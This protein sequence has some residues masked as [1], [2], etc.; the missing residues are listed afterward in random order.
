MEAS[1]MKGQAG[2]LISVIL[3]QLIVCW[4]QP[5]AA[6][7]ETTEEW[8]ALGVKHRKRLEPERALEAF[9]RAHELAPTARSR[10][11]MGFVEHDLGRYLEA[12]QHLSEALAAERDPWVIRNRK[13][14]G[15]ALALTRSHLG[16]VTVDGP[17]GA[18]VRLGGAPVG[19]LPLNGPISST[20]GK[21]SVT[22][23]AAGY[24]PWEQQLTI[25]GG[26][27][28]RLTAD[29]VPDRRDLPLLPPRD[30]ALRSDDTVDM[31]GTRNDGRDDEER[32][33]GGRWTRATAW[34]LMGVGAALAGAAVWAHTSRQPGCPRG[35]RVCNRG[36]R[37]SWPT[38][39]LAAGSLV[40]GVGSM[41]LFIW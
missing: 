34:T 22:V 29:L 32:P 26:R 35:E 18:A 16:R 11:Q 41:T 4:P 8:N 15:E 28:V 31:M 2:R 39:G 17:P 36:T 33:R 9:R 21:T 10:G 13:F 25:T 1:V 24:L 27:Q 7:P 5:G 6:S 20:E 23:T 37:S 19:T 40:A 38:I 30:E 3:A 14:L 12:E